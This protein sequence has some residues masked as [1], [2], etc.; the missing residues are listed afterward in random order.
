MRNL[1]SNT[2]QVEGKVSSELNDLIHLTHKM[3]NQLWTFAF[4]QALHK[5]CHD[6]NRVMRRYMVDVQTKHTFVTPVKI[7]RSVGLQAVTDKFDKSIPKQHWI[8]HFQSMFLRYRHRLYYV[9]VHAGKIMKNLVVFGSKLAVR[10]PGRMLYYSPGRTN[11]NR[12][13]F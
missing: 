5:Q 13:V 4:P 3:H 1:R 6:I 2:G 11:Q 7:T 8:S 9:Y 12:V 10:Y